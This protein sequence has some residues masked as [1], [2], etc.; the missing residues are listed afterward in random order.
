[1]TFVFVS[2]AGTDATGASGGKSAMW[3][4]VKGETENAIRAL[5]FK[6]SYMFRPGFIRPMHGI[7]SRTR[8]YRWLYAVLWPFTPII[9][10]LAPSTT[11]ENVG[12]AMLAVVRRG[13]PSPIVDSAGINELANGTR[14][15]S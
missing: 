8:A 7:Q 13:A 11:T 14:A 10:A 6:A 1:M 15:L 2:G 3:A 5:P 4:R 9:M 12:K